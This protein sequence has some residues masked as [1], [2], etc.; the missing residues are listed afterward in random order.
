MALEQPLLVH[1]S[2][3]I[4]LQ[5][6]CA[7]THPVNLPCQLTLSTYPVNFPCGRKH[8]VPRENP[9]L[10]AERGLTLFTLGLGS[11][12]NE[13]SSLRFE[14][15]TLEVKG[16]CANHFATEAPFSG[17]DTSRIQMYPCLHNAF[18]NFAE[19]VV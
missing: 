11:S 17:K 14:P 15:A 6:L 10:S 18:T 9:R 1:T 4:C 3:M 19:F 8:G 5:T 16:N 2:L 12:H 13:K 7:L